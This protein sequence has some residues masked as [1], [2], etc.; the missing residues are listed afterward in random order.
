MAKRY[1]VGL[2]IA[3]AVFAVVFLLTILPIELRRRSVSDAISHLAPFALGLG[4]VNVTLLALWAGPAIVGLSFYLKARFV[5]WHA[6]LLV[7]AANSIVHALIVGAIFAEHDE[8]LLEALR[9]WLACPESSL[10]TWCQ[11]RSP[12]RHSAC[13]S[14]RDVDVQ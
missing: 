2:T 7:G 5:W 14:S 10:F 1:I 9:V 13:G 8:T 12:V 3:L 6:V 11:A 4:V